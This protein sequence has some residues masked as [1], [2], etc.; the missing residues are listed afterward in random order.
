M[1]VKL[2]KQRLETIDSAVELLS[3]NCF[4]AKVDLKAAYRSDKS[5]KQN[6]EYASFC[7]IINIMST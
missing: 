7:Y 3:S 2:E 5:T 4:M 1:A 6:T